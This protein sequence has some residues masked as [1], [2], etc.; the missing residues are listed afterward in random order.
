M[1]KRKTH[2]VTLYLPERYIYNYTALIAAM[3]PAEL[4]SK[5]GN[6]GKYINV[7]LVELWERLY[8]NEIPLTLGD[9]A[10]EMQRR[11]RVSISE[12][13]T[14]AIAYHANQS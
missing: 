8:P 1:S 4:E 11:L 9:T 7:C 3:L 14:V 13:I 2:A 12:I 6:R 5:R 10:K